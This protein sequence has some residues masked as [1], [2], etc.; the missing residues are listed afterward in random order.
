MYYVKT[1]GY[2][3]VWI[4]REITNM[5]IMKLCYP[6][7]VDIMIGHNQ[8]KRGVLTSSEFWEYKQCDVIIF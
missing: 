1:N 6:C 7:M 8:G 4:L 2:D 5:K 3:G